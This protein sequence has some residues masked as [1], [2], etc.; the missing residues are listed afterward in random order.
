MADMTHILP[1]MKPAR[2]STTTQCD[3]AH[4]IRLKHVQTTYLYVYTK[5]GWGWD[6]IN[7]RN[8]DTPLPSIATIKLDPRVVNGV[9]A[10]GERVDGRPQAPPRPLAHVGMHG[11]GYDEGDQVAEV[12]GGDGCAPAVRPVAQPREPEHRSE[13]EQGPHGCEGVRGDAVES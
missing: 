1:H 10:D 9:I 11:S 13:R 12:G 3:T 6:K 2:V 7:S 4:Y 5:G 8:G